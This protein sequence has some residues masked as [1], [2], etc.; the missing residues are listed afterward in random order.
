ML[1]DLVAIETFWLQL[2]RVARIMAYVFVVLLVAATVLYV[3][4]ANQT[5]TFI[6]SLVA[7]LPILATGY[8]SLYQELRAYVRHEEVIR[9]YIQEFE[10]LSPEE[11]QTKLLHDTNQFIEIIQQNGIIYTHSLF[12]RLDV[13][14]MKYQSLRRSRRTLWGRVKFHGLYWLFLVET[15]QLRRSLAYRLRYLELVMHK[16][17]AIRHSVVI[18]TPETRDEMVRA[19]G[20]TDIRD[21]EH[22]EA[23]ITKLHE[24]ASRR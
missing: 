13:L 15:W 14:Y 3:A 17:Q 12:Q 6:G 24:A 10:N 22:V 8:W 23:R 9:R 21:L 7:M 16:L 4:T 20:I 2:R 19:M 11:R 1:A 5:I 18:D